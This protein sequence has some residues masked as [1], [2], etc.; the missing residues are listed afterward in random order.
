MP[1]KP[2]RLTANLPAEV[3]PLVERRI[4]EEKYH[5][6]SAYIVGLIL[7]DLYARRPHLLTSSLMSEPQWVRDQVIAELVRDFDD[8][9]KARGWFEIRIEELMEERRRADEGS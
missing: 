1:L 7:F 2:V 8:P 4:K 3:E 9:E 5:S 6:V